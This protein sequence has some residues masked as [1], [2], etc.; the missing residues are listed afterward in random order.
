[1]DEKPLI[2][3]AIGANLP[4]RFGPPRAAC[5]AALAALEEH[6]VRVLRRSRWWESAPVPVSDQPWYVNG[7][8]AVETALPPEGLLAV[9]HAVE[10]AMG[11]VRTVRNAPRVIDLDLLA[12]GDV[13]L[14]GTVEVPHPRL[15]E[16][17]F[18]V[19][20]LAE[21]APRW[22]HPVSGLTV[23]E[24]AAALPPGQEIRPL[25]EPR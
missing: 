20:P 16:R 9:L 6:G 18:V 7:V 17:A 1:M 19:L 8:A 23:P 11:R 13:V 25:A 21:V 15:A 22:R 3:V 14:A 12:Y 4:S 10:E 2:L 5:D 24:M